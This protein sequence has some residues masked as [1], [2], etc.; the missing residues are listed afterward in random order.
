MVRGWGWPAS[1][2]GASQ[3]ENSPHHQSL[4]LVQ[5]HPGS[6]EH[7]ARHRDANKKSDSSGAKPCILE[8]LCSSFASKPRLEQGSSH[9]EQ[10]MFTQGCFF[11][12]LLSRVA[13]NPL[14]A[15]L[16]IIPRLP[17][18]KNTRHCQDCIQQEFQLSQYRSCQEPQC[19]SRLF[20]DCGASPSWQI[21]PY[22]TPSESHLFTAL[23]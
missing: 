11:T 3:A 16:S 15:R 6:Q 22:S 4:L 1:T 2:Q 12:H 19:T 18:H 17:L 20:Q 21:P 8:E 10:R 13:R 5:A 9:R 23:P 14:S 7:P